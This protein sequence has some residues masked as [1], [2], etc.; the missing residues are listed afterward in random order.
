MSKK[1]DFGTYSVKNIKTFKGMEGAGGFNCSLYKDGK[2]IG[3]AIDSDNGGPVRIE[4]RD[5]TEEDTFM[6]HAKAQPFE[7]KIEE[8]GSFVQKMVDAVLHQRWLKRNCKKKT[9][10]RL[11]GDKENSFRTI[12]RVY[13][14]EIMAHLRTTHGKKIIE[15]YN[16]EGKRL[17]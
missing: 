13:C 17:I 9:L 15:L 5:T 10:F 1:I 14:G 12:N 4:I 7:I 16:G 8:D 3:T 2:K 6:A 11:K